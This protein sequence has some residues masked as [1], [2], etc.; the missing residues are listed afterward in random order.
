MIDNG[1]EVSRGF[2]NKLVFVQQ[3]R[4]DVGEYVLSKENELEE[5]ETLIEESYFS[6]FLEEVRKLKDIDNI[7][8]FKDFCNI[9]E[10]FLEEDIED[11]LN[12]NAIIKLVDNKQTTSVKTLKL[13]LL[14]QDNVYLVDNELYVIF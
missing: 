5:L 12:I 6:N 11:V 10:E 4:Y 1:I 13:I 14:D 7:D 3:K 2:E 8:S 9:I